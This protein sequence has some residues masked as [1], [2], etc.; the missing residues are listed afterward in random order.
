[1]ELHQDILVGFGSFNFNFPHFFVFSDDKQQQSGTCSLGDLS[2][3]W[4]FRHDNLHRNNAF[5][6]VN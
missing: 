2:W 1:M 5:V 6:Y 4:R 3:I